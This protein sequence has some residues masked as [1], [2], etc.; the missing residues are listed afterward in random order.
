[1]IWDPM[2]LACNCRSPAQSVRDLFFR[3][4]VSLRSH[5]IPLANCH[6]SNPREIYP[7]D[8]NQRR[9]S[10]TNYRGTK[11]TRFQPQI[12]LKKRVVASSASR[13]SLV[14]G[15][16]ARWLGAINPKSFLA[17]PFGRA[18][19]D[20]SQS[21]PSHHVDC[22]IEAQNFTPAAAFEKLTCLTR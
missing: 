3:V 17:P 4:H 18:E 9:G 21:V 10:S 13:P 20:V 15:R 19:Y 11:P 8:G 7:G 2:R 12:P 14:V 1:M 16:R 5:L 6:L 22:L